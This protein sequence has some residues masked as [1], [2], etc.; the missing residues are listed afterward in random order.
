MFAGRVRLAVTVVVVVPA[1]AVMAVVVVTVVVVTVVAS[2][3]AGAVRDAKIA[4]QP[5]MIETRDF[6]K[7]CF[8]SKFFIL[9]LHPLFP[10]CWPLVLCYQLIKNRT[11]ST[12]MDKSH[13]RF[14]G[15]LEVQSYLLAA[16]TVVAAVAALATEAALGSQNFTK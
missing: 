4:W 7:V 2:V 16:V 5:G 13:F 14:V 9:A 11:G 10:I 12:G 6:P 15:C 8:I 3:A 1:A